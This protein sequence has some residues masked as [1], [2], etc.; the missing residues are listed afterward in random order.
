[1]KSTA[2]YS[3]DA[4]DRIDFYEKGAVVLDYK[5][6]NASDHKNELQLAAYAAILKDKYGLEPYGYGWIGHG[7]GS[8]YGYFWDKDMIDAYHSP[9]AQKNLDELIQKAVQAMSDMAAA[10][11]SGEF[12]A[13]YESDRCRYCEFYTVCRRK[14][15]L[16]CES[17]EASETEEDENDKY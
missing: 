4:C 7:N 6:N 15:A 13:Y 10:V 1:M 11:K 12:P 16:Y 8:L 3:A 5:S 9:K 17:Y 14:E 2:L